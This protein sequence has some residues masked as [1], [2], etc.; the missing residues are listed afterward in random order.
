M[1]PVIIDDVLTLQEKLLSIQSE[2]VV[3]KSLVNTFGNFKYRSCELIQEAVKP[4][5]KKYQCTLVLND[6]IILIGERYYVKATA[7]IN[8]GSNKIEV[9]AYAREVEEKTKMDASQITGAASSYARK[10]ALNGLFAIDDTKDADTDE[11][12]KHTQETKK[13]EEL[14]SVKDIPRQQP[15]PLITTKEINALLS[16]AIKSGYDVEDIKKYAKKLGYEDWMTLNTWDY[17]TI[18][19]EFLKPKK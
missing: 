1:D 16:T 12:T 9:S 11:V 19:D 14:K 13:P 8:D 18:K 17:Q 3:P 5:L 7:Q 6:E 2:L 15:L 4:L 10:Y